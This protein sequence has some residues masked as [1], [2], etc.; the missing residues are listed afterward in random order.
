MH[1]PVAAVGRCDGDGGR[2]A[3]T[4][5]DIQ[6]GFGVPR[7]VPPSIGFAPEIAGWKSAERFG[8]RLAAVDDGIP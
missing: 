4:R 5:P 1:L 3:L 6:T 2:A 7:L 8:G